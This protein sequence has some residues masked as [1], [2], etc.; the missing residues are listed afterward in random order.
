[1]LSSNLLSNHFH[2]P[3]WPFPELFWA[4]AVQSDK[5]E[6]MSDLTWSELHIHWDWLVKC[7]E[8][9]KKLTWSTDITN[10]S[11]LPMLLVS[12][13]VWVKKLALTVDERLGKGFLSLNLAVS[14]TAHISNSALVTYPSW[15]RL[16]YWDGVISKVPLAS[17]IFWAGPMAMRYGV[18]DFTSDLW[19]W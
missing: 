19:V 10:M 18:F 5:Y 11:G 17:A 16:V 14:K 12:G 4:S 9:F 3:F 6:T 1:M 15:V 2:L 7:L 13:S 8:V